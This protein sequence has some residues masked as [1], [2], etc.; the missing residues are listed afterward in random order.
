MERKEGDFLV[1]AVADGATKYLNM[2]ALTSSESRCLSGIL[3]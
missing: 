1:Q 2:D 3:V